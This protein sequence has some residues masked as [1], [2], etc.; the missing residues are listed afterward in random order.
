MKK[1]NENTYNRIYKLWIR[2]NCIDTRS[3]REKL[4]SLLE[5]ESLLEI[6]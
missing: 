4:Q 3:D 2:F 5:L 1:K 6:Q